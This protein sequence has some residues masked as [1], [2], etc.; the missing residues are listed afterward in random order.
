MTSLLNKCFPAV[1]AVEEQ[2][3]EI[4]DASAPFPWSVSRMA[5]CGPANSY[6]LISDS[7]NSFSRECV[8]ILLETLIYNCFPTYTLV[9]FFLLLPEFTQTHPRTY[10][11]SHL[12]LSLKENENQTKI[13]EV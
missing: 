2:S 8:F 13:R 3:G 10:L 4:R 12:S 5:V 7:C 11:F 6:E 1:F 9:L